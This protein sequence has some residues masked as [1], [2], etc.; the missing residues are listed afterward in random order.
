M[1]IRLD[2]IDD[3]PFSWR[4]SLRI[5]LADLDRSEVAALG[6][7]ACEGRIVRIDLGF[8]LTARLDYE[9]T[10]VCDRCLGATE[11]PVTATVELLVRVEEPAPGGGEHE[12]DEE[13]LGTLYLDDVLL[14]TEPLMVEQVQLNVPMKPLCRPDCRGLCPRCGVDLNAG[15]CRCEATEVDPRWAALAGLRDRLGGGGSAS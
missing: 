2:Q 12:I 13:E 1:Q 3:E 9:Q 11:Q 15:E 10:L 14:D 8:Y 6:E 4:E 7:V 5:P